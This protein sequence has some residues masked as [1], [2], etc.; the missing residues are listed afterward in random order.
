MSVTSVHKDPV[1]RTMTVTSEFAAPV[2]RVWQLWADPRLLE[3]WWGPPSH[4]ATVVEHSLS[5]GGK[6]SY[7][8]TGPDGER[9]TGWWEVLTVEAPRWL[10]FE[11]GDPDIPTMTVRV[12]LADREVPGGGT[13][14]AI[15]V[16]FGS[17]ESM[18]L[19]VGMG[20][21]E[22]LTTAIAQIDPLL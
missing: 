15:E 16:D 19:L 3:R 8:V 20:F 7:Y 12:S 9:R 17:S 2:D 14:M 1:A 4:P 13:R 11:M 5:P 18:D 22:G 10:V 21:E 6:V